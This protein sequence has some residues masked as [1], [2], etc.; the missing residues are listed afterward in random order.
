MNFAEIRDQIKHYEKLEK[1]MFTTTSLQTHSIVLLHILSRINRSIPIYFI[2]T[3]YHFPETMKFREQVSKALNIE[4][5]MLESPVSKHLQKDR[6]NLLFTTDP[7]HCCYL[8]KIA[9]VD[10]LLMSMDVWIN[11]VRAVQNENRRNLNVEEIAAHDTLRFHP[12][13]DWTDKMIYDY[14]REFKLPHHPRELKG[15]VSIGCEPCTRKAFGDNYRDARWYGQNKTE[16]GLNTEL[17]LKE[18]KV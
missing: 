5:N 16:C 10:E 3:G 1:R 12:L 9:P 8:N 13:L 17:I 15:Y 18:K 7:D 6:G 2:N 14:I 11:G 4:I